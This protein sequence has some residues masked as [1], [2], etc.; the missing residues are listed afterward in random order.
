MQVRVPR[1]GLAVAALGAILVITGAWWA[2]ALWP[3]APEAPEWIART[4]EVCFG[5]TASG[6]PHVGG[7][8]LLIGEP[9][10]MMAVLRVV[11]GDDLRTDLRRVL[12][13]PVGR[14]A[15]G[16]VVFLVVLGASAAVLRVTSAL[17]AAEPD[18]F[19]LNAPLPERSAL[20]P[21]ALAL[22]D[23]HGARVTLA[24][25]RGEWAI[26]TFA[27]GHCE[28]ICPVIVEQARQARLDTGMERVPLIVVTLDPWRD[29]PERLTSIATAWGLAS[30]DRALSGT[31]EEVNA[32]LD[33]WRVPR[34]RDPETGMIGHGALLAVIDPEGRLAWRLDGSPQRLR[35]A[36][37]IAAER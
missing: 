37:T 26:V 36:L 33:A 31:V 20:P 10:G 6:L 19:S 12:A 17:R 32:A 29:T 3:L 21:P 4:R 8:L 35:E 5:T 34:V 22:I 1:Q 18:Y 15:S 9:I 25:F 28:D 30:G 24:S 14:Y 7:W 27:F 23:Q 16:F 13:R 2:L 11:W